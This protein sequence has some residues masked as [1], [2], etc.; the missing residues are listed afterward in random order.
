METQALFSLLEDLVE[1]I[2][3]SFFIKLDQELKPKLYSERTIIIERGSYQRYFYYL[4]KGIATG[5]DEE[6]IVSFFCEENEII[7][8]DESFI[9]NLP[10]TLEI[11][12]EKGSVVYEIERDK[13]LKF[14]NKQFT[15][16]L[17]TKILLANDSYF[18]SLNT[19]MKS[20]SVKERI[21]L[22]RKR[23]K[24]FFLAKLDI[25]ASF[26]GASIAQVCTHRKAL[27]KL[28]VK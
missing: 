15:N 20:L 5:R 11:T 16:I 19:K 21:E 28:G 7:L 6:R 18:N 27:A 2:P 13:F 10:S 17:L 9:D 12:V 8:F 14:E 26:I 25:L 1:E 3:Q 23:H 24:S 22:V 4:S